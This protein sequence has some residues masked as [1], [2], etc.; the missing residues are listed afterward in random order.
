MLPKALLL[1]LVIGLQGTF[2]L[3]IKT[4]KGISIKQKHPY[5][6]KFGDYFL[7]DSESGLEPTTKPNED[8]LWSFITSDSYLYVVNEKT[9]KVLQDNGENFIS[10]SKT[11]TASKK[12]SIT[13]YTK[14]KKY[15]LINKKTGRAF[16]LNEEAGAIKE[17]EILEPDQVAETEDENEPDENGI[18]SGGTYKIYATEDYL[19]QFFEPGTQLMIGKVL[20]GVRLFDLE[21]SENFIIDRNE[22]GYYGFSLASDTNIKMLYDPEIRYP[23]L[24]DLNYM[25]K[26]FENYD[27]HQWKIIKTENGYK[28]ANDLSVNPNI[29]EIIR[30]NVGVDKLHFI[31]GKKDVLYIYNPENPLVMY[32]ADSL[33]ELKEVT[34]RF[35]LVDELNDK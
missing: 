32:N 35:E 24:Q 34:F 30:F 14:D 29:N 2:C 10:A 8:T 13:Y 1:V 28:I 4:Q 11:N 16:T 12:W 7:K 3:K 31:R 5:A 19:K 15:I 6:F 9:G 23:I 21:H 33:D 22:K 27:Y 18:I 26:F 17:F 25:L 20:G